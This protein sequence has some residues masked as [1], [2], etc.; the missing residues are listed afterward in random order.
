MIIE[1]A[2]ITDLEEIL[3]LQKLAYLSEA[4]RYNDFTITPLH[5]TLE[6]IQN[7]YAYKTFLKAVDS[8]KIVGSV[9]ANVQDDTCY[10]GRLI[11]HPDF[12]NKGIGTSLMKGIEN[13]FLYCKSYE[14]FTGKNS[15]KNIYLYQ[16][17]GYKIYKE[18]VVTENLS[19]VYLKK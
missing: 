1:T 14:L 11:V 7:E 10:I 5:Q 18:E 19:F 17:L 9:R 13:H 4:E 3:E 15:E 6:D 8:G 12:Q 2:L 16:K